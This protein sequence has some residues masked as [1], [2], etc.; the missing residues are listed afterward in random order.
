MAGGRRRVA[1]VALNLQKSPTARVQCDHRDKYSSRRGPMTGFIEFAERIAYIDNTTP[2]V[3]LV[4]MLDQRPHAKV[5]T[6]FDEPMFAA[7]TPIAD[8]IFISPID[9]NLGDLIL[10]ACNPAGENFAPTRL[11]YRPLLAIA[12][13]PAPREGGLSVFDSDRKLRMAVALTRL[14]R[15]TSVGLRYSA[16]IVGDP[17]SGPRQ[18]CPGPVT[19]MDAYAW[20]SCRDRDWLAPSDAS[21]IGD[22]CSTYFA[23]PRE[24]EHGS[25][26]NRRLTRALYYHEYAAHHRE[27]DV[28][29]TLIATALEALLN[30][31]RARATHQF[32]SRIPRLAKEVGADEVSST[33]ANAM[34]NL[35]SHL[36]HGVGLGKT[37]PKYFAI[38]AHMESVL[39]R[40][41]TK[42]ILDPEFAARFDTSDS[43]DSAYPLTRSHGKEASSQ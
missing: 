35:R 37:K 25:R 30:T 33:Q 38:Y 36:V 18:V 9:R 2:I 31:D 5:S 24:P 28:R 16:R 29:W 12:R 21:A 41:L 40:C 17:I 6:A 34:Y 8:D 19:H 22:L 1:D 4:M 10:R 42:C 7:E 3:D 39:R 32:T 27:I 20:T 43:I 14:I 13:R 23:L 26:L 15:P 11:G